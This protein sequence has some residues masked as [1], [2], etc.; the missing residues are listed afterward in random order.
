ME[1]LKFLSIYQKSNLRNRQLNQQLNIIRYLAK[2]KRGGSIPEVARHIKSSVPTT[3]K[4][5]KELLEKQYIQEEGKRTTDNG[6]RPTLYT[7]NREKFYVVG[8]EILSKWIHVGIY[9]IDLKKVHEALNRQFTLTYT[10]DCLHYIGDFIQTAIETS[11]INRNQ[12]IGVGIGMTGSI[13]GHTGEP[14]HYFNEQPIS[15]KKWLEQHLQLPIK[16]D[17]DTRSIGIAEQVLGR[18][19]GID[20]VLVVKVSR[21]LGLSIILD[22]KIILGGMGFAGNFGHTQFYRSDRLCTCGKKGCLQTI[23]SGTALRHDLEIA[24]KNGETSIHFQLENMATYQYHNILDAVLKGDALSIRLLQTQGDIL[25]QALG[26]VVNLLNPDLIVIGGEFV[27]VQD[28]FIDAI[29]MGIKK[30]A[31]LD[32]L[33]NCKIEPSKLGRYLSSKAGACMLLKACDLITC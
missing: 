17:N 14:N 2:S 28:F 26:N 13:N 29:R 9:R 5:V 11:P 27:M 18:A 3:T 1:K 4:L 16:I 31:L 6:R 12:I 10:T 8:V 15:F 19:N 20:N 33:L 32:T 30:T 24:L 23:V 21:S 25:G 22:K 7:I